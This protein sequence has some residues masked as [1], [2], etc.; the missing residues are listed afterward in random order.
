MISGPQ[1]R[2]RRSKPSGFSSDERPSVHEVNASD[3]ANLALPLQRPVGHEL[4]DDGRIQELG[5]ML[6]LEVEPLS[7]PSLMGWLDPVAQHA[8]V[9]VR[10]QAGWRGTRACLGLR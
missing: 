1:L 9:L 4:L 10:Q 6:P 3:A 7:L 2:N 5:V 8:L